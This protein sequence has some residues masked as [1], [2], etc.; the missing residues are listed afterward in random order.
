MPLARQGYVVFAWNRAG[1][2]ESDQLP[3]SFGHSPREQLWAFSPLGVQ[4]TGTSGVGILTILLAAIDD[5]IAVSAPVSMVS[6]SAS[7][8]A[9]DDCATNP[10]FRI[11]ANN[12]EMSALIAPKPLLPVASAKDRTKHTPALELPMA[13]A[14]DQLYGATSSI[15]SAYIDAKHNY[16]LESREAVYRFFH[17]HLRREELPVNSVAEE[18]SL[19]DFDPRLL[20]SNE[21]PVGYPSNYEEVFAAWRPARAANA[22]PLSVDE[23]RDL[24]QAQIGT[25]WPNQVDVVRAGAEILL[26]RSGSGDRVTA[27]W[28]PPN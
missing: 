20:L 15:Q 28:S 18:Y 13:E 4:V 10:G 14:L 1:Y 17:Q 12:V 3:H 25:A 21:P 8:Q 24:I 11:G 6:V 19:I 7:F 22:K 9:N 27:R 26:Q 16:T 2:N 23:L 5:R